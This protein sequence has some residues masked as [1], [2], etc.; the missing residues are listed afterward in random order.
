MIFGIKPMA[1]KPAAPA[2]S[3]C[4]HARRKRQP[5][6]ISTKPIIRRALLR[7]RHRPLPPEQNKLPIR[8]TAGEK[9][10]ATRLT[11]IR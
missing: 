6:S 8:I 9:I 5:S 2:L 10:I 3:L 11:K 7:V 4:S 1:K